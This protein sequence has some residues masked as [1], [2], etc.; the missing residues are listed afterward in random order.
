[1]SKISKKDMCSTKLTYIMTKNKIDIYGAFIDNLSLPLLI[2]KNGFNKLNNIKEINQYLSKN[3]WSDNGWTW[4]SGASSTPH[5]HDNCHETLVILNGWA[6]IAWGINADIIAQANKGDVIFQ[7]AGLFHAGKG[8]SKTCQTMG[9][10]PD[11]AQMWEFNYNKPTKQQLTLINSV[12]TPN[13]PV[14]GGKEIIQ[15]AKL[16]QK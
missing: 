15:F 12:D 6:T 9:I 11:N 5:Y 16:L 3:G 1:M 8:C 10:Y 2:Y 14:F 4:N 7:P 13:D